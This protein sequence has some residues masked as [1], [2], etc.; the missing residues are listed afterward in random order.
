MQERIHHGPGIRMHPVESARHGN[1][2]P[3]MP[4]YDPNGGPIPESPEEHR[5]GQKPLPCLLSVKWKPTAATSRRRMPG[6]GV[7]KHTPATWT[8]TATS[9][10][11]ASG[12]DCRSK[13][14]MPTASCTMLERGVEPVEQS[15]RPQRRYPAVTPSAARSPGPRASPAAPEDNSPPAPRPRTTPGPRGK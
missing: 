6:R 13:S 10:T 15:R 1:H 8:A 5:T 11:F 4:L 12:R 7:P 9:L 3:S 2:H 14:L